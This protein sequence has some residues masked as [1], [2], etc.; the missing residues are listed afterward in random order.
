VWQ[1]MSRIVEAHLREVESDQAEGDGSGTS[2]ASS[3]S[4]D[5]AKE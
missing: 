4:S 3:L 5:D 2:G 1:N